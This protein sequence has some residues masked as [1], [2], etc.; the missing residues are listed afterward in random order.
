MHRLSITP[1]LIKR[2]LSIMVLA[3]IPIFLLKVP[4]QAQEP[5]MLQKVQDLKIPSS[6]SKITVYYSPGYKMRALE[7]RSMIEGAMRYYEE[8]LKVKVG[9]SL[10]VLNKPQFDQIG[11]GLSFTTV[12]GVPW[13]S[14]PPSVAFLPATSDGSVNT[15]ILHAKEK[16]AQETLKKIK[17]NG[18]TY[19]KAASKV[20][21][22]IGLHELGHT[23][24]IAYGIS[25]PNKWLSEFLA[26]YFAYVYLAQT[27]PDWAGI[28]DAMHEVAF[29]SLT[30]QYT[31]L[32][33]FER[34]YFGVGPQN[35]GW[36]QGKFVQKVI[37]VNKLKG[38]SFLAE[39]RKAFPLEE[40]APVSLN[41][42]LQRLEKIVPGF[43]EWAD[44]LGKK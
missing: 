19:E 30:P 3:V 18:F 28:Y 10:A 6:T 43:V 11:K 44:T 12:Y 37:Q 26:H 5:N 16:V 20:V 13:V 39:V 31:S 42:G 15:D 23:Y 36:Y 32:E 24:T 35:Y 34:L 22:L 33:D 14:G 41:E 21:D 4:A 8:R 1:S 9:I 2:L 40:K 17:S 38:L 7:L 29:Q 25:R 27:H